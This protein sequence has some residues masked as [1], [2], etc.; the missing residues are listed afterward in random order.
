MPMSFIRHRAR[1]AVLTCALLVVG[2]TVASNAPGSAQTAWTFQL[3]WEQPGEAPEHYELC[4]NGACQW[5]AATPVQ[6][7]G[8]R[9]PLP[10]LPLGEH[11]LVVRACAG[12]NCVAGEPVVYVR[13]VR[14]NP[15]TPPVITRSGPSTP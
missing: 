13:V 1:S 2:I 6:A 8:W 14:P 7:R 4:I 5:L 11:E 12:G 3:E 10:R 15:R 9:A